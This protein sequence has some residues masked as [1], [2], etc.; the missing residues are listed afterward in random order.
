MLSRKQ[1]R[2]LYNTSLNPSAAFSEMMQ[3]RFLQE[4]FGVGDEF[5]LMRDGALQ[6]RESEKDIPSG[7]YRVSDVEEGYVYIYTYHKETRGS[8]GQQ[9]S[10][11]QRK[12]EAAIAG[13]EIRWDEPSVQE[14]DQLPFAKAGN[15]VR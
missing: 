11:D 15:R 10:V 5:Y 12:L 1:R 8:G 14:T 4:G 3:E 7:T 2:A 9:F 6:D 13:G